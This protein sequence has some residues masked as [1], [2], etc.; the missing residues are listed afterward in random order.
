MG[1][2]SSKHHGVPSGSQTTRSGPAVTL[3]KKSDGP[4]GQPRFIAIPDKYQSLQ[5]V[6]QA[7]RQAGLESSNLL[8]GIDYTKS[9]TWNGNRTFQGKCLHQIE[10]GILNPYQEAI[11]IVG[12]TL[13]AF[14]DDNLIP[15]FGFGDS[16]TTDKSVFKFTADRP[17]FGF[18]EVLNTYNEITPLISLSGPTSF[19]PLIREAINIVSQSRQYHILVI[20]ADGEVTV[21]NETTK[22][23]VE[24]S[25]YPLSI[26]TVGVGDGPWDLMEKFD[27]DLPERQFD[28]FQ[29][30]NYSS[31]MS[32]AENR[33]VEF[34]VAA[35]QEIPDQFAAIK[36]LGLL[37]N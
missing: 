35:L 25:Q 31:I 27:D 26:I 17:C 5:E 20:I 11:A 8:I 33:K 18:Q 9:N 16:R 10:P 37:S 19:A 30:V 12:E 7:L 22:A 3:Q 29:F 23:I 14:D 6:Q 13:A 32:K 36:Q 28:N 1:C 2:G 21:V 15:C 24:A 34:A 4:S